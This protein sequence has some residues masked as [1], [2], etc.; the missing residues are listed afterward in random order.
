MSKKSNAIQIGKQILGIFLIIFGIVGLFL[1][2]MQGIAFI[3]AGAIILG[4]KQL[5]DFFKKIVKKFK[6]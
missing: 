5:L 1:P 6:K 2:F 3:I 4:N